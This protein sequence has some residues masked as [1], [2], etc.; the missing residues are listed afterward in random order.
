MKI[1]ATK[2]IVLFA[3]ILRM[4]EWNVRK[5]TA[6]DENGTRGVGGMQKAIVERSVARAREYRATAVVGTPTT[7]AMTSHD[8]SA[9]TFARSTTVL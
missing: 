3:R 7:Q 6:I 4:E 9:A 8:A 1:V 2:N 5:R